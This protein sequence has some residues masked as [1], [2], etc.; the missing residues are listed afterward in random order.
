MILSKIK[1]CSKAITKHSDPNT[2]PDSATQLKL[3]NL[4]KNCIQIVATTA[5]LQNKAEITKFLDAD[6]YEKNFRPVELKE[7]IK[8]ERQIFEVDRANMNKISEDESFLIP[9]RCIELKGY[10]NEMKK[11]DPDGLV[12]L[13]KEVVPNESCLIFCPTKKNCE[14]VAQLLTPYLA[15]F[16]THKRDAK[17][18]LFN[19]IKE[20][21]GGNVC[22]I[23][24]QSIQVGIAYHH[25]GLFCF[26]C[27]QS[28]FNK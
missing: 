8:M 3:Q 14:N 22:P 17:L 27:L 25:S 4:A 6:F 18:K 2:Q 7:Y 23:L 16:K 24:R 12:E 9:T 28:Y 5:T 1:Y 26:L 19:E 11:N 21:N 20:E 13:V 15:E 10:T